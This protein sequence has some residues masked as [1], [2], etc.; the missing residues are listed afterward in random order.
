MAKRIWR[1][2]GKELKVIK[3][4]TYLIHVTKE[5]RARSTHQRKDKKGSDSDETSL[6][7]REEK[8]WKELGKKIMAV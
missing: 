8:I 2:K 5:W 1:W 7:N 3:E 4:Y 6:R